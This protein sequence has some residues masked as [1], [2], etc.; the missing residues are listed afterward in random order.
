[1]DKSLILS[2][3]QLLSPF[4]SIKP[5][6]IAH[7]SVNPQKSH[8]LFFFL[9]FPL[10]T[11][12]IVCD[13]NSKFSSWY[14]SNSIL[15][16]SKRVKAWGYGFYGTLGYESNENLGD[17]GQEMSDYLPFV[18]LGGDLVSSLHMGNEHIC[19]ILMDYGIKCWG[20]NDLGQLG[21][22]DIETIG[23]EVGEMGSYLLP[24][25]ISFPL[26]NLP[27]QIAI[28]HHHT[29]ILSEGNEVITWGYNNQG[30]LGIESVD[31]IGNEIGE[32]GKNLL[33]I[34]LGSGQIP[35]K[36][37][38]SISSSCT[39]MINEQD[40][41]CWG[42]NT[43]G[44][45]GYGDTS[46]RGD[47]AN[48][49]GSYLEFVPLP[50]GITVSKI[51]SGMYIYGIISQSSTLYLWGSGISGGLGNGGTDNIGDLPNQLGSYLPSVKLGSGRSVIEYSGGTAC[52]CAILDDFSLKCWGLNLNGKLGYGHTNSTGD[53]PNEMSDYL[54]Q[55]QLPTGFTPQSLHLGQDF[56]CVISSINDML[57]WGNNNVG[58][59]GL[60]STTIIGDDPSEMGDYLNTI[61]FGVG[62]EIELCFDISPTINPSSSPIT[63]PP[64]FHPTFSPSTPS[65][66]LLPTTL[67][68]SIS[69]VPNCCFTLSTNLSKIRFYQRKIKLYF[70]QY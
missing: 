70:V 14:V 54:N 4:T 62:V 58:Q 40:M 42:R 11:T 6:K 65:P 67:S 68:P 36:I 49:M 9:M 22:E 23:D 17:E 39:L 13:C 7:I 63:S 16:T 59:L 26:N 57:C 34:N 69:F 2:L 48:S 19:V 10:L 30:Q 12:T 1:M 32:M 21:H 8:L 61:D 44:Q 15:T 38:S 20:R 25:N 53:E 55:V 46:T 51:R 56:T 47:S 41:K 29:V 52:G 5:N 18:D 60:G 45:L 27:T 24:T 33:P 3:K 66:S 43:E 28:G 31:Y 50:P 64:T 35:Y 37:I